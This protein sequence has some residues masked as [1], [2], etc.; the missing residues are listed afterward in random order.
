MR[1][2]AGGGQFE[3]VGAVTV[4]SITLEVLGGGRGWMRS[5]EEKARDAVG[6]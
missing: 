1:F 5:S 3:G 2:E 4:G 6:N